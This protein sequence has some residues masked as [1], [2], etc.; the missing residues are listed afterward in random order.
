MKN[1][2]TLLLI[3]SFINLSFLPAISCACNGGG[4]R[5]APVQNSSKADIEESVQDSKNLKGTFNKASNDEDY[6]PDEEVVLDL[7]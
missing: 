1:L 2:F 7:D 6:V 3:I 5:V 4:K